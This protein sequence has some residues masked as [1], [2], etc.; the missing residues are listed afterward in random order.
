M[1][2]TI[3]ASTPLARSNYGS[4]SEPLFVRELAMMDVMEKLT[5]KPDWHKKVFDEEIVGKWKKEALTVPDEE[6]YR[7]ATSGKMQYWGEDGMEMRDYDGGVM[8]ENIMNEGAFD[9]VSIIFLT[10]GRFG[11]LMK[12]KVHSRAA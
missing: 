7:L 8:P 10:P 4:E 6:M 3:T 1:N 11:L 9:C 5:D 2:K 12:E